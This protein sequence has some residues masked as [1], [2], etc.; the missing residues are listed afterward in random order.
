[1]A[2]N[3]AVVVVL[4]CSINPFPSLIILRESLF[5]SYSIAWG[6]LGGGWS[7]TL[8]TTLADTFGAEGR[9]DRQGS[10]LNLGLAELKLSQMRQSFEAVHD[11]L[12]SLR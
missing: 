8:I 11:S 7:I 6:Q 9:T 1:M 10:F 12:G 4:M 2:F 3:V 5:T